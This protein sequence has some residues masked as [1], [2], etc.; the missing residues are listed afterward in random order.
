M[1]RFSNRGPD[2]KQWSR[3]EIVGVAHY[4]E[5]RWG[6]AAPRRVHSEHLKDALML[7]IIPYTP[8]YEQID[9]KM[10]RDDSEWF[11]V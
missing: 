5:G 9:K 7:A 3:L 4:S 10:E 2:P 8:R 1:P 6:R 11:C